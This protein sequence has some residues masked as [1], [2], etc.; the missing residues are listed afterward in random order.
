MPRQ[1]WNLNLRNEI[2]GKKAECI[3]N[4]LE[5]LQMKWFILYFRC[6]FS[7]LCL[8]KSTP[9]KGNSHTQAAVVVAWIEMQ[10]LKNWMT[11][12][13][14]S[15]CLREQRGDAENPFNIMCTFILLNFSRHHRKVSLRCYVN[16]RCIKTM[17]RYNTR[18]QHIIRIMYFVYAVYVLYVYTITMATK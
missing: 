6:R 5:K 7:V 9:Q 12:L 13:H 18:W 10:T 11:P 14:F 8:Q 17:F 3:R 2:E 1:Q 15:G 16:V 4:R